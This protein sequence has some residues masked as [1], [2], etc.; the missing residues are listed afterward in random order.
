MEATKDGSLVPRLI[1]WSAAITTKILATHEE[2][3]S[4]QRKALLTLLDSLNETSQEKCIV[5]PFVAEKWKVA[6]SLPFILGLPSSSEHGSG[7]GMYLEKP[8]LVLTTTA[9]V[10]I[11]MEDKMT[12]LCMSD[13]HLVFNTAGSDSRKE[14]LYKI[15]TIRSRGDAIKVADVPDQYHVVLAELIHFHFLPRT[16]FSNIIVYGNHCL[17]LEEL[18]QVRQRFPSD[19]AIIVFASPPY[20]HM[21]HPKGRE[22]NVGPVGLPPLNVGLVKARELCAGV[23]LLTQQPIPVCSLLETESAWMSESDPISHGPEVRAI[24]GEPP[25][26]KCSEKSKTGRSQFDPLGLELDDRETSD[27]PVGGEN[28]LEGGKKGMESEGFSDAG[29]IENKESRRFKGARK[30]V[31]TDS[32]EIVERER[33]ENVREGEESN[34]ANKEIV[35]GERFLSVEDSEGEVEEN[36]ECT[37]L[38]DGVMGSS[39]MFY[40]NTKQEQKAEGTKG[41]EFEDTSVG[42]ATESLVKVELTSNTNSSSSLSGDDVH[43]RGH[44]DCG[45]VGVSSSAMVLSNKMDDSILSKILAS[46]SSL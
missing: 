35:E 22:P 12:S 19:V 23:T 1:Q 32:L 4:P 46:R 3:N 5:C 25:D 26:I 17:D 15:L 2:L 28:G 41:E 42:L 21:R 24:L 43:G 18:R 44:G 33:L 34:Q 38:S 14:Q 13:R 8:M 45:R 39:R 20:Q 29:R 31:E 10:R 36:E 27:H 9:V 7:C 16:K 37:A 6:C 30:E 11:H 40:C